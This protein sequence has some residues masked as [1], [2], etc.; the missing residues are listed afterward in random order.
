VRVYT[1]ALSILV[2]AAAVAALIVVPLVATDVLPEPYRAVEFIEVIQGHI[3]P[4]PPPPQRRALSQPA[5]SSSDAAPIE[6]PTGIEPESPVTPPTSIDASTIEG[7]PLVGEL[8]GG[9]PLPPPSRDLEPVR[10]GG[11]ISRP[12]RIK[13]VAPVYPPLARAAHVEG[14]VILEAVLG[15]DGFVREVRV[16]RSIRLLDQAALQAVEQW[17][18]TPTLLNGEPV[19][20]V[21]TVTVMF[22]L[23]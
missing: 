21:L 15:A 19:P 20:V 5:R 11:S 1:L 6:A 9:D 10:V 2:H 17:Q 18:F 13:Y 8:A 14:T 4:P 22:S 7:V 3:E 23:R 16:L 12:E